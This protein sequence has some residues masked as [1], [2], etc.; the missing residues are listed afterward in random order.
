[1]NEWI[2]SFGNSDLGR[3]ISDTKLMYLTPEIIITL[4]ILVSTL[5]V[6]FAKTREEHQATWRMATTGTFLALLV[7]IF[8]GVRFYWQGSGWISESVWYGMFQADLFSLVMRGLLLLGTFL[9]LLFSRQFINQQSVV[10][11]EFYVIL[12]C[13]LLGG[14]FLSGASD[15]IMI[16]IALETLG[17]SSY[18]LVAFLRGNLLSAEAGLKYLLYGGMSTAILLFGFSLLYGLTGTTQLY[19]SVN[20]YGLVS[21]F[22]PD[23]VAAYPMVV[24]ILTV[25]ILGGV[26][27]K[28]S[29]APFHMWTPDVYEGAPT[30]VTAYLSVVSKIAGFALAIRLFTALMGGLEGWF[31][32]IAVLSVLS[33]VIG[34]VV[35]LTQKNIKRLLAYSTVAH[36]GYLLMGLVVLTPLGLASLVYY[37]VAYLFMNLGAF[38]VVVHFGNLTGR[39]DI[40]SY[41]G[42]V[43]ARPTLALIFSVM[44]LSLA[45]IPI[46]S[47]F[48]AKFFIFQAVAQASDAYLWLVIVALLTS[49]ISLYYYLNV[50][51]L[52]VIAEP[53]EAVEALGKQTTRSEMDLTPAFTVVLFICLAGTLVLGL[54]AQPVLNLA[55]ESVQSL[56]DPLRTA[57]QQLPVVSNAR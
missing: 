20:A 13:G 46:T 15:L 37:L 44:L 47:G 2:R 45:G 5:W 11:G 39:D 22:T 21:A 10:P 6:A 32:L 12:L 29:A 33:M 54:W 19:P 18:I 31:T 7:L 53:S 4:V 14:M 51:R 16:F 28:L 49:T 26:C 30:P 57:N 41:A 9:V 8:H 55:G 42:L 50:I 24:S 25:M 17:I 43:R 38:A 3:F 52:M 56:Q 27:F 23:T 36:V 35:A 1:M 40:A 48:F 34:N